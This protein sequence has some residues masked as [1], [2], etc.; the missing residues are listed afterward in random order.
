M[1][2]PKI[3]D[4]GKIPILE[5][6]LPQSG[7]LQADFVY[8]DNID[9]VANFPLNLDYF[10]P[11]NCQR[12]VTARL[13]FKRRNYRTYDTVSGL[14]TGNDNTDH[15]HANPNTNGETGHSHGH[16]HTIPIDATTFAANM[17]WPGGGANLA[18]NQ[19][20]AGNTAAINGDATG[21]SGHIHSQGNTG[22][23]SAF[24]QHA[25]NLTSVLGVTEST[26][27]NTITVRFD[28]V[29][30][31]ANLTPPG[32]YTSDQVEMDVT[33]FVSTV[34]DRLWHTISFR[35]AGLGRIQ[36]VLRILYNT[37]QV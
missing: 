1:N 27:A 33:P 35:P 28:G 36:A 11:I 21:S 2:N 12:V 34:V 30:Q 3:G 6:S 19:F 25:L 32:P 24:H 4:Q 7:L 26:L 14:N 16:S 37:N 17:F 29:D 13:S 5:P 18:N 8:Q 31:T 22:G 20:A 15:V 10:I 23:R 9:G